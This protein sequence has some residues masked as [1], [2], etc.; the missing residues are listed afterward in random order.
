[1]RRN[2]RYDTLISYQAQEQIETLDMTE[3]NRP[4]TKPRRYRLND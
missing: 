4:T 3:S 1:V 2:E